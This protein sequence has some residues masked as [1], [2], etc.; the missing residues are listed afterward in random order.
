M[1][2]R[3]SR[4]PERGTV[5]EVISM[6]LT[7][8]NLLNHR[9]NHQRPNLYWKHCSRT[10]Q[11]LVSVQPLVAHTDAVLPRKTNTAWSYQNRPRR[12]PAVLLFV[13]L[14]LSSAHGVVLYLEVLEARL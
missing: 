6:F 9:L 13:C 11:N 8:S 10:A 14:A 12:P 7:L 2:L 5:M 4:K 3:A 1:V